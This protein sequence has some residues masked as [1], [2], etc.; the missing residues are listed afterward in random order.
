[1]YLFLRIIEKMIEGRPFLYYG[2]SG[3]LYYVGEK[4]VDVAQRSLWSS[5]EIIVALVDGDANHAPNHMLMLI[6]D[7]V[8]LIVASSPKVSSEKRIKQAST[9][10]KLAMDLWSQKELFL[11]WLVFAVPFNTRM[12]P[13]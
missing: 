5:N 9:V 6:H 13:L 10:T 7:S 12:K 11:T 3:T 1:M 4:G 8:Q 2:S